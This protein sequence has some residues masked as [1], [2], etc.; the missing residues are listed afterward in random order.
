ALALARE[1]DRLG[2]RRIWYAEHHNMPGIASSAPEVIIATVAAQ[3]ERIRVGSGGVMLPNHAPLMVA[4]R[5]GTLE[6]LHPGRIDLGIGRAPGSDP[7]TAWALRRAGG[8]S[9]HDLPELL[10]ELYGYTEGFPPGH[11]LHGLRA[12]PGF[13]ALPPVWLLGSSGSS[14][15]LAAHLGLPFATAHHFSPEATVPSM[16]AYREQFTPSN[17]QERPHAMVTVQVVVADTEPEA[18]GIADAFALMFLRMRSGAAPDVLPSAEEVAAYRWSDDERAWADAMLDRQ[19]V[20]TADQVLRRLA[21]LVEETAADE[22]M[23]TTVAPDPAARLHSYRLL[24]AAAGL[25][26]AAAEE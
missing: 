13:G 8:A 9:G 10:G 21:E 24:A 7:R 16:R 1:A 20:G 6:A 15:Q 2:Y 11:D 3:T 26:A 18:R 14:A 12:T 19:A 25:E 17:R 23:A 22:V 4:E 5:F